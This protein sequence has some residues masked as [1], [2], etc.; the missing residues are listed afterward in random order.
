MDYDDNDIS[1][2]SLQLASE[3]RSR[4]SSGLK[5]Y[6]FPKFDFDDNLPGHLR[7]DSLVENEVFLGIPS[8]EDNQ[9]IED[10]SQVSNGMEFNSAPAD[11]CSNSRRDNVWSE[12]TSSESVEMLLKSVGQEEMIPAASVILGTSGCKDQGGSA[13][14]VESGIGLDMKNSDT[15]GPEDEVHEDP[16]QNKPLEEQLSLVGVPSLNSENAGFSFE[17]PHNQTHNTVSARSGMSANEEQDTEH[18]DENLQEPK[19]VGCPKMVVLGASEALLQKNANASHIICNES[20]HESHACTQTVLED[21][22]VLKGNTRESSVDISTMGDYS[23]L[24]L[25]SKIQSSADTVEANLDCQPKDSGSIPSTKECTVLVSE[26]DEKTSSRTSVQTGDLE[27]KTLATCSDI[28][29]TLDGFEDGSIDGSNQ[30]SAELVHIAEHCTIPDGKK[31]SS[32]LSIPR[33]DNSMSDD[34]STSLSP[35]RTLCETPLL[36]VENNKDSTER[37]DWISTTEIHKSSKPNLFSS[38]VENPQTREVEGCVND[39]AF[40][41]QDLGVH[42]AGDVADV[43]SLVIEENLPHA[44][45]EF[46]ATGE[47]ICGSSEQDGKRPV[48][49]A[50]MDTGNVETLTSH[51]ETQSVGEEEVVKGNDG[52]HNLQGQT[53]DGMETDELAPHTESKYMVTVDDRPEDGQEKLSVIGVPNS[54]KISGQDSVI[55]APNTHLTSGA[56]SVSDVKADCDSGQSPLSEVASASLQSVKKCEEMSSSK[57]PSPVPINSMDLD[58]VNNT[59]CNKSNLMGSCDADIVSGDKHEITPMKSAGDQ[60]SAQPAEVDKTSCGS[61]TIISS[62]EPSGMETNDLEDAKGSETTEHAIKGSQPT[63][64]DVKGKDLPGDDNSFTFKVNA[65]P[66]TTPESET[67]WSPFHDADKCNPTIVGNE[68]IPPSKG[69]S[70]RMHSPKTPRQSARTTEVESAHGTSKA[71]HERKGR[72][73]SSKGAT[74]ETPKKGGQT[75]SLN[76]ENSAGVGNKSISSSLSAPGS[77]PYVQ[78]GHMQCYGNA[79]ERSKLPLPGI[80]PT[81]NLP[82]STSPTLRQPFTDLQQVQLRAQIFVYGSLIQGTAPDEACMVSAFGP[83]DAGRITWD[84]IWR[85]AVER[86]RAQKS[87]PGNPETPLPSQ[88]G[89]RASDST[90]KHSLHPSKAMSTPVSKVSNKDT[91]AIAAGPMIPLSSPLWSISTPLRDNLPSSTMHKV[92]GFQQSVTP[93]HSLQTPP[94]GSFS[95]HSPW[96]SQTCF[97]GPW[98]A[99]PQTTSF[100]PSVQFQPVTMTETVKLTPVRDNSLPLASGMKHMTSVTAVHSVAPSPVFGGV[101][102][103]RDAKPSELQSSDSKP[104]KRKKIATFD[105]GP[106]TSASESQTVPVDAFHSSPVGVSPLALDPLKKCEP[107]TMK[108]V[109][110]SEEGRKHVLEAKNQAENA[111]VLAANAVTECEDLWAKLAKRKESGLT[112]DSESELISATAAIAAA[113][114]VAKAA[115]AA[116]KVAFNAAL[117]AKLLANEASLSGIHGVV[118]SSS[119]NAKSSTNVHVIQQATP[120]SI[121]KSENSSNEPNSI[122]VAAKEAAKRRVEAASAA[123]KQAENLDAIVKAAELAASAV[124]QAGKIVAMGDPLY[125]VDL[126]EAGPEGYWKLPQTRAELDD[127][128]GNENKDKLKALH[129]EVDDVHGKASEVV[130]VARGGSKKRSHFKMHQGERSKDSADAGMS[131]TDGIVGSVYT[132][133]QKVRPVRDGEESSMMTSE[134]DS[135]MRTSSMQNERE[136]L[137][138]TLSDEIIKQGSHVEVLKCGSNLKSAWYSAKVV[139]LEDG[140]AYVLYNDLAS[141]EESGNLYEWVRL[142]GEGEKAPVIRVAYPLN[143]LQYQGTRKR[144][145]A[146]S[147]DYTWGTGDKVDVWIDDCWWEGIVTEKNEK[148][149]TT[150]KVHFP[151]QG[152]TSTVRAWNL[153]TSRSWIDGKWVECTSWKP[154]H[155][156]DQN[157]TPREK[158]QKMGSPVNGKDKSHNE[159]KLAVGDPVESKT[160]PLSISERTFDIGKTTK[161]VSKGVA[162]RPLRSGQQKEGSRVVFGVP[163]PTGKTQKFMEVSK[164]FPAS[165]GDKRKESSEQVKFPKYVMPQSTGTQGWKVPSRNYPKEKRTVESRPKVPSTRKSHRTLPQRENSFSRSGDVDSGASHGTDVEDSAGQD[166][167]SS[168]KMTDRGFGVTDEPGEAPLSS[169]ISHSLS[170]GSKRVP[171]S[172]SRP[173]RLNRGKLAPSGGKLS[174]IE[175]NKVAADSDKFV[176]E[177]SGPRRSNRR[178]QPTHRVVLVVEL[179]MKRQG[180]WKACRVLWSF[181]KCPLFHMTK[182]KGIQ[183]GMCSLEENNHTGRKIMKINDPSTVLE[184]GTSY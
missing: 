140:K 152:E 148:D 146:A 33:P 161:E 47:L 10:Y 52:L 36:T 180:Y 18:A 159:E 53:S 155:S 7:F 101:S 68:S 173:G 174:K 129:E 145:R 85:T 99:S 115:A 147:G 87:S 70:E 136:S 141:E 92:M 178:F 42:L 86:V 103:L 30:H 64:E 45:A 84:S 157:D 83:S 144:R 16:S 72:R 94:I 54:D 167:N 164:H 113:A 132:E 93:L 97:P 121:L 73:A 109:T 117:Q 56:A 48:S 176:D 158:R 4:T 172:N 29:S 21:I 171:L 154:H 24:A 43:S 170:A 107:D 120:A 28:G 34:L 96:P 79:G 3:G 138:G 57:S 135:A 6:D 149:E 122:L 82:D 39:A 179:R 125:L 130:S 116:A 177:A 1:R 78:F 50:N 108:D 111:S 139:K 8:Q 175:E 67:S 126:I 181:P 91:H 2:H 160:L 76:Q 105:H 26:G 119:A 22:M 20:V 66:D 104:R 184:E 65:I 90:V 63:S 9:W 77:S 165:K 31:D 150:L 15:M 162:R 38:D 143:S 32:V 61:P 166:V 114:S 69:K 46:S 13:R 11:S 110:S 102:L 40:I 37:A 112:S 156:S 98:L 134:R 131:H 89:A 100:S 133:G 169:L 75:K 25:E 27:V 153:R 58:Q 41:Q 59:G 142:D 95:G 124:S 106:S 49:P 137:A 183:V 51:V 80:L 14:H 88:S 182:V 60:E 163:K 35:S 23:C 62:S 12:A 81:S 128:L 5:P 151:A 127:R 74:K 71:T 44:Q 19:T 55:K 17:D 118:V 123:S 168:V